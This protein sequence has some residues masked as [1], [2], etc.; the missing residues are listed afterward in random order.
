VEHRSSR[1]Q[2]VVPLGE[3]P[4]ITMEPGKEINLCILVE[5]QS[6]QTGGSSCLKLLCKISDTFPQFSHRYSYMGISHSPDKPLCVGAIHVEHPAGGG[7]PPLL[8]LNTCW[9]LVFLTNSLIIC[10]IFLLVKNTNRERRHQ[11][12]PES[13]QVPVGQLELLD[14]LPILTP[15]VDKSFSKFLLLHLGHLSS[16]SP[17]PTPTRKSNIAPH[18][19]HL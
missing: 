3:E 15:K 11:S 9:L 6:G 8:R 10:Q 14:E 18:C 2:H 5:P 1:P 17:V 13:E 7:E 19:L 16:S 12:F 4:P